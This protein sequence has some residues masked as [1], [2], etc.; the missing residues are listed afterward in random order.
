MNKSQLDELGLRNASALTGDFDKNGTELVK[1]ERNSPNSEPETST[2]TSSSNAGKTK[3]NAADMAQYDNAFLRQLEEMRAKQNLNEQLTAAANS[4]LFTDMFNP[5]QLPSGYNPFLMPQYAGL[6]AA[7]PGYEYLNPYASSLMM[8]YLPDLV[9]NLTQKRLDL[10]QN[11]PL[12]VR[13]KPEVSPSLS[14]V[15]REAVSRSQADA[16]DIRVPEYKPAIGLPLEV[17]TNLS[18]AESLKTTVNSHGTPPNFSASS[19]LQNLLPFQESPVTKRQAN[20]E[21]HLPHKRSKGEASNSNNDTPNTSFSNGSTPMG[22]KRPKRGQY[23]K[24]DSELLAQAVR[25]VQRGE[26]SVHRA[27]TFFGVPHS[28]LEYKVKERH[29]LRKKKMAENSEN[30]VGAL[31]NTHKPSTTA[32]NLICPYSSDSSQSTKCL[33]NSINSLNTETNQ[34]DRNSDDGNSTTASHSAS[35]NKF[36][37]F[38][39]PYEKFPEMCTPASELLKRL[40]ERAQKR[41]AEIFNAQNN[42]K[43]AESSKLV[44]SLTN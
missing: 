19:Y 10:E 16:D 38:S 31:S 34:A 36:L 30:K 13:T 3:T 2:N 35:E 18:S 33:D 17:S 5:L 26:M 4:R 14:S 29:L 7:I 8:P 37:D 24:Y 25:A 11:Q 43:E 27:G 44:E 42:S 41:A 39:T 6:A 23:R 9:K 21:S 20:I 15:K 22:K 1:P 32:A 12:S 40:H 28:T